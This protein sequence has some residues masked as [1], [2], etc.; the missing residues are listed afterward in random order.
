MGLLCLYHCLSFLSFCLLMR[1]PRSSS[2][3]S[4][5][6]SS[7]SLLSSFFHPLIPSFFLLPFI[8][9]SI[10]IIYLYIYI[11]IFFFFD[12]F[13]LPFSSHSICCCS[14]DTISFIMQSFRFR[15]CFWGLCLVSSFCF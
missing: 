2:S 8:M 1:R 9:I 5:S 6:S 7:L 14:I 10:T 13:H 12:F 3:S 15:L 11:Y 4:S